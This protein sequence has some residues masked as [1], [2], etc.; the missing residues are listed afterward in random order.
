MD[1]APSEL[2]CKTLLVTTELASGFLSVIHEN[3]RIHSATHTHSFV[4]PKL[5]ACSHTSSVSLT[6]HTRHFIHVFNRPH[7]TRTF[8]I[9]R[10]TSVLVRRVAARSV[11]MT[12]SAPRP[13]RSDLRPGTSNPLPGR[14][15]PRSGKSDSRPGISHCWPGISD[16][17]M[18]ISG[19]RPGISED[20]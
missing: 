16:P 14:S 11:C 1:L 17:W 15:D 19:P 4:A 2:Q 9:S 8:S 10:R 6:D 12:G 13:R 18:G 3:M 20:R 5:D 7:R